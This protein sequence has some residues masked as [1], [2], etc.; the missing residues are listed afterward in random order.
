MFPASTNDHYRGATV[1]AWFLALLAIGTIVPGCIHYF[2]PDGGAEVI[3]GLD[4]GDQRA[5]VIGAFAWM[6][7][8]QIPYGLAQLAVATRYRSLVPLFL[9]L[10]LVERVLAAIAGWITKGADAPHHPPEHYLVVVFAPLILIFLLL[11][12]RKKA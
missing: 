10:A 1:A 7:A 9:A 11:S 4:L 12:L 2:L 3:A 6:G 5:L 8:T